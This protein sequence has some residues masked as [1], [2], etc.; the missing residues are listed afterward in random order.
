[1]SEANALLKGKEN[2]KAV[3][4]DVSNKAKVEE[5]VREADVIVRYVVY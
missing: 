2:A 1:M 3:Q 4:M 5:L